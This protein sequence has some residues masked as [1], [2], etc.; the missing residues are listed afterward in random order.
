MLIATIATMS[1]RTS[2]L[3]PLVDRNRDAREGMNGVLSGVPG[4]FWMADL[5][6]LG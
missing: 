6:S 1:A 3:I 4:T 5:N 2:V